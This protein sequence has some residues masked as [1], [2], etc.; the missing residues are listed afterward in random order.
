MALI[1]LTTKTRAKLALGIADA[2]TDEDTWLDIAIQSV[3]QRVE[4]YLDRKVEVA[5]RTEEYDVANGRQ[6]STFLRNYP[7]TS[8]TSIKNDQLWDFATAT[9]IDS[10]NYHLDAD[11]G[12]IHYAIDLAAG[13]KAIQVV[14]TAGLAANTTDLITDYPVIAAAADLQIAAVFRRRGSPQG[15]QISGGRGGT[16]SHESALRLV[17]EVREMLNPYRRRRFGM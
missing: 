8:I 1:E 12:E 13:P 11:T 17:P 3:S 16:I 2:D 10:D 14:Y 6:I 15:S 9:A 4:D 7:V 5:A